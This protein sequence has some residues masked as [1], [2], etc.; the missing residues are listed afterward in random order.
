MQF[1]AAVVDEGVTQAGM[2]DFVLNTRKARFL[3]NE[4]KAN[5]SPQIPFRASS[6][7]EGRLFDAPLRLRS[8]FMVAS[9][10]SLQKLRAGSK[11]ILRG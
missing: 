7:V 4:M 1:I 11:Y 8:H 9:T 10:T 5:Q 2:R 6:F 3:F